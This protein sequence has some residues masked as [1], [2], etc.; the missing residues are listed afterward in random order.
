M[1]RHKRAEEIRLHSVQRE[2]ARA[3]E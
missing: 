1:L 2:L 3:E